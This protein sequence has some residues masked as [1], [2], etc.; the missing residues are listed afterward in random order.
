MQRLLATLAAFRAFLSRWFWLIITLSL[1]IGGGSLWRACSVGHEVAAVFHGQPAVPAKVAKA[2]EKK[3]AALEA[4]VATAV[5]VKD[6]AIRVARGRERR[7]D[8]LHTLTDTLTA[9]YD[10]I[11]SALATR[12]LPDLQRD[13][14][15]YR[16]SP[17]PDTTR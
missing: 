8:S 10:A 9:R 13:L 3:N 7:A 15:R 17:F 1:L 5:A 16:P 2:L 14:E 6:S 12:A 11:P 4:K